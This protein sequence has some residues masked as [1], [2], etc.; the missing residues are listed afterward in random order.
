M[1]IV[2]VSA[3]DFDPAS[4]RTMLLICYVPDIIL[5]NCGGCEFPTIV[6]D[7]P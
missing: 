4:E 7:I 3:V 2:V 1:Q 5:W 6:G